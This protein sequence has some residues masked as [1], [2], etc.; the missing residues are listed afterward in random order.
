MLLQ[1]LDRLDAEMHG[2]LRGQMDELTSQQQ[3]IKRH[4]QEL[5]R[6][7]SEHNQL[8]RRAKMAVDVELR[9][10]QAARQQRSP[11]EMRPQLEASI[12]ELREEV[13][14]LVKR[15]AKAIESDA[16]QL[17]KVTLLQLQLKER[18]TQL[19]A[20]ETSLNAAKDAVK[21]LD[22]AKRNIEAQMRQQTNIRRCGLCCCCAVA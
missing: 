15:I 17:Q 14:Q 11:L 4:L 12:A 10:L 13:V 2:H 18:Q 5:E 22:R 1:E 3:A 9:K 8:Q 7:E 16:R 21:E 20:R 19:E 6:E